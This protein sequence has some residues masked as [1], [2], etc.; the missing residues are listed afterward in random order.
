MIKTKKGMV[1]IFS[2]IIIILMSIILLGIIIEFGVGYFNTLEDQQIYNNNKVVLTTINNLLTNIKTSSIGTDMVIELRT[3]NPLLFDEENNSVIIEQDI[4]NDNL[5]T[6]TKDDLNY[7]NLNI[8]KN[9]NKF[10]Y[11]LD[12]NAMIDLNNS[13]N[14][15]TGAHFI[16]FNIIGE[17]N[18]IPV[19]QVTYKND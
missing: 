17:I 14:L 11:T 5:Y 2:G 4:R 9:K 7:G 3:D 10:I 1:P 13:L 16:D 19:V 18:N 8:S 6:K 12:L 15:N